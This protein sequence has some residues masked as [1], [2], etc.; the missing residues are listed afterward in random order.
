LF[1]HR[2]PEY[3]GVLTEFG[4]HFKRYMD[5]LAP[6]ATQT[7]NNTPTTTHTPTVTPTGTETATATA[8]RTPPAAMHFPHLPVL[9]KD[10][11]SSSPHRSSGAG[12]WV[13][14][15]RVPCQC[16]AEAVD[17]WPKEHSL[18]ACVKMFWSCLSFHGR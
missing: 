2:Y 11:L 1:D 9:F 16:I 5:A 15:I 12:G 10:A 6:T 14:W 3:P 17:V 18:V 7:P 4:I 13:T 8:S